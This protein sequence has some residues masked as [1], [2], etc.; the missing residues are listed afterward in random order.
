MSR[1]V[2]R[3]PLAYKHPTEHNPHWEFQRSTPYGRSVPAS[4]LHAP[5]DRF[6]G[7]F[8]ASISKARADWEDGR[9]QW[10][11]GTHE[12]LA[13]QMRYHSAEGFLKRDGTRDEPRPYRVYADDGETFVRE[14]YPADVSEILAVYPYSDYAFEPSAD[15]HM[16]DFDVPEDELGWCLY[17][18]VSEGIPVTPVFA[19]A[20]ELIAH[21]ATVGQDW[22]QEPMRRAAAEAL[23][24]SGSS[25][26]SMVAVGGVLYKSDVDADV[27]AS[28]LSG[29]SE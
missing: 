19:T 9:Q 25:F 5:E 1:E 27:L 16:P 12:H 23:V 13:F 22:D 3:V 6:V 10:E 29:G 21:L 2:R 26:G 7:L 8:S 28:K 14:F 15:N 18:T 11:T 4:Q 24:R 20:D 17:E